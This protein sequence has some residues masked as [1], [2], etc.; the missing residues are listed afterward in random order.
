MQNPLSHP[1]YSADQL[2]D[3]TLLPESPNAEPVLCIAT[4]PSPIGRVSVAVS[5]RAIRAIEFG[6]AR[7]RG[8]PSALLREAV[9][10]LEA[11][12]AGRLSRFDLPLDPLGTPFQQRVWH[13]LR[14]IRYGT[15]TTYGDLAARIGNPRA[16]R[17][18]GRANH[19]NPIAIV[20]PCHRVV[21]ANGALTGYAS[22]IERKAW[23]LEHEQR[24]PRPR[25]R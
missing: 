12:F 9:R 20:I 18:V 13:R 21:G 7:P 3:Q 11:Y 1:S 10:Q 23:L 8:T 22:G 4:L 19:D 2:E 16:S 6:G 14:E 17:A 24:S 5:E 15:T 25:A